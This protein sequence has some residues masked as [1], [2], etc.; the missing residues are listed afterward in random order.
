MPSNLT[1]ALARSQS[2]IDNNLHPSVNDF[3]VCY[4]HF[5]LIYLGK[6]KEHEQDVD[7]VLQQLRV[8]GIYFKARKY[9]SEVSEASPREY[10]ITTNVVG[11]ASARLS[12]I[13]DWPPAKSVDEIL[14][15]LRLT[16]FD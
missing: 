2:Y 3:V 8:L 1:N 13:E 10:I 7:Q 11:M 6:E 9:S 15:L 4:L 5:T 16:M 12:T 14:V